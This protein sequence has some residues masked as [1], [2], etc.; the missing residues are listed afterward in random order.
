LTCVAQASRLCLKYHGASEPLHAQARR[1]CY[2]CD[3]E[4]VIWS[5]FNA[6]TTKLAL[7][8]PKP[9]LFDSA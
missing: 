5:Y 4:F 1:L 7:C 3:W 6:P 8:P 2:T 9:K